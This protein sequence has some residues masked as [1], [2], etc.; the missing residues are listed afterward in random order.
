MACV[1]GLTNGVYNY[2]DC[3]GVTRYGASLGESI[4]L[5]ENFTGT[6]YGVLI[7]TGQTCT[8]NCIQGPLDYSFT[9]SG[10]CSTATGSVII[11]PTGGVPPYTIDNIIPGSISAQTSFN[12][13]SFTGLTGGTYVFRLNDTLGNQNNEL[14]IKL[15]SIIHC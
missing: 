3:C 6:S 13:I 7:A 11:S 15:F 10:A 8:I 1:S 4:C 14:F 5:D 2:V 12:P 9:V